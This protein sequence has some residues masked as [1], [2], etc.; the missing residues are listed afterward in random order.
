[1]TEAKDIVIDVKGDFNE[2]FNDDF[3]NLPIPD[4]QIFL[5]PNF[6][7]GTS[8]WVNDPTYPATITDNGDGSI[9]LKS[10][11][12]YGSITPQQLEGNPLVSGHY[13]LKASVINQTGVRRGKLSIR[14]TGNNWYNEYFDSMDDGVYEHDYTGNIKEIHIGADNDSTFECDFLWVSLIKLD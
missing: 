6:E 5:N 8:N 9:H 7:E 12:E 2:D 3:T 4:E 13:L 11:S 14:D 1:M 10:D